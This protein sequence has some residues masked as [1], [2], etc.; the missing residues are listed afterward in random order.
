MVAASGRRGVGLLGRRYRR[1]TCELSRA[2]GLSRLARGDPT[3]LG[4]SCEWS[5]VRRH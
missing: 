1:R 4:F 5:A 3:N 2:I